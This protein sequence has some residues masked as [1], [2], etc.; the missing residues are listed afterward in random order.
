[1]SD[2]NNA[3][4]DPRFDPAF[5]R[6][7]DSSVP[8]ETS[9]PQPRARKSALAEPR[10]GAA[11]AAASA[12]ASSARP[13]VA[14]KPDV[15]EVLDV[16]PDEPSSADAASDDAAAETAAGRNPFL[17]L[18][19]IIA[20][21]LFA[22]GIWLF[23]RSGDEFNSK[24]VQSQGDYMS[25]TATINVAPFIAMLGAVTAI[26]VLFVYAIRWRKRR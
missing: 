25:L 9:T 5:Q 7:F 17:L 8:I 22:T 15:A 24:V 1:M 10:Q 20:V 3:G 18:L 26:G 21:A 13:V 12:P 14:A 16:A 2:D 11:A 6:G 4:V 19:G 23:V